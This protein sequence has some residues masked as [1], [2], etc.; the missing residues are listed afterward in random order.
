MSYEEPPVADDDVAKETKQRCHSEEMRLILKKCSGL[1]S[2]CFQNNSA[3]LY[4]ISILKTY[5]GESQSGDITLFFCKKS[6]EDFQ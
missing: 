4:P 5:R 2:N 6:F 3:S 1:V